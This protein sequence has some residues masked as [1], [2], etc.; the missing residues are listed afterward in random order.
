MVPAPDHRA[1]SEKPCAVSAIGR[2]QCETA[3]KG[4]SG[5]SHAL[6]GRISHATTPA[7]AL[8]IQAR[9]PDG[10]E[11]NETLETSR[12]HGVDSNV[13]PQPITY[14]LVLCTVAAL[15]LVACGDDGSGSGTAQDGETSTE[16]EATTASGGEVTG[17]LSD[18]RIIVS[19]EIGP[20]IDLYSIQPDGQNL[21]RL[22]RSEGEAGRPDISPDRSTIVYE[23]FVA[24][25]AVIVLI[26]AD[27]ENRRVLTPDGFQ[28]QPAWSPDGSTIVF[29]RDPSAGDNGVWLMAAD[30]S[31]LRRLTRNPFTSES[32]SLEE[33]ACDTDP[34]FSGR[35]AVTRSRVNP[36]TSSCF[37]RMARGCGP[38][39]AS[40]SAR[41]VSVAIGAQSGSTPK[42]PRCCSGTACPH[43]SAVTSLI[44]WLTTR[45]A[46]H[47][48]FETRSA[49]SSRPS[50]RI[51]TTPCW[52]ASTCP[53]PSYGEFC[54]PAV[55]LTP[56]T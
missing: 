41:A 14:Q 17:S 9:T 49:R 27:G 50:G 36:R 15:V 8:G 35:H 22:T 7:R 48:N 56:A 26:D 51:A 31:D 33:S 37:D 32:A 54:R 5:C 46:M 6:Q 25:R 39:S 12:C 28:G 20:N 30:G 52:P 10:E 3:G 23:D 11:R 55:R 29:E 13:L 16:A 24:D 18:G 42:T 45:T 40:A 34:M 53:A 38:A 4:R 2:P 47:D 19:Q 43:C 1:Q 44:S 21:E